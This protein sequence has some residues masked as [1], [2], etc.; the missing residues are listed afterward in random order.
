MFRMGIYMQTSTEM[1]TEVP[2]MSD[3]GLRK[4]REKHVNKSWQAGEKSRCLSPV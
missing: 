1:G 3:I 2:N 4:T